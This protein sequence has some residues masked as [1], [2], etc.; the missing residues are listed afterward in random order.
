MQQNVLPGQIG[1]AHAPGPLALADGSS[2]GTALRNDSAEADRSAPC[3][4]N[5]A[6]S[7][8]GIESGISGAKK[9]CSEFSQTP[10]PRSSSGPKK[11]AP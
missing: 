11:Q 4:G 7:G 3:Y 5:H 6:C 1:N 2:C 9:N 10:S 8:T